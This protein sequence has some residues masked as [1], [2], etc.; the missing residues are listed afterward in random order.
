MDLQRDG[1]TQ[2]PT[3]TGGG[4]GVEAGRLLSLETTLYA[5]QLM[6]QIAND[7]FSLE[8]ELARG[9]ADNI[10]VVTQ[11]DQHCGQ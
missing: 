5:L 9:D 3:S 6:R 10:V 7:L 4:L 2:P 8:K 11:H 1:H